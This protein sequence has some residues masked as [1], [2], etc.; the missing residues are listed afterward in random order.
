MR[1]RRFIAST[2]STLAAVSG[3]TDAR[4]PQSGSASPGA[5]PQ[6]TATENGA[7]STTVAVESAQVQRGVVTQTSPDS[8]EVSEPDTPY[9]A[10]FVR[11]EGSLS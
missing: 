9:L 6:S 11:A 7:E 3:C 2:V 8:I 10:A 1:R 5:E 4:S